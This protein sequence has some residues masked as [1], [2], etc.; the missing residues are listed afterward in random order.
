M[1]DD[2]AVDGAG[3]VLG[4]AAED[5]AVGAGGGAG[6]DV[7]GG[8][9]GEFEVRGLGVGEGEVFVVVVGVCGGVGVVSRW[10]WELRY[11]WLKDEGSLGVR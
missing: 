11:A 1:R 6:V 2:G 4:D 8:E 3:E 7:A 5:D 10:E 9:D